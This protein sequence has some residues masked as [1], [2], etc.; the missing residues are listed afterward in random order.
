[1][2]ALAEEL[3]SPVQAPPAGHARKAIELLER[4]LPLATVEHPGEGLAE[5]EAAAWE[6]VQGL[7]SSIANLEGQLPAAFEVPISRGEFATALEDVL[8]APSGRVGSLGDGMFVGPISAAAE[9]E[10]RYRL[11]GRS[12]GGEL[13]RGRRPDHHRTRTRPGWR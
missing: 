10:L 8:D 4:Y 1:M 9:L 3:A 2:S 12:C 7:L 11:R 13:R 5:A 6:E